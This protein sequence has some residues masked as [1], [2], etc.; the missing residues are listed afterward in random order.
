MDKNSRRSFL[1]GIWPARGMRRDWD[2]RARE[3]AQRYI[4]CGHAETD[5]KFW[6]SGRWDLEHLVLHDVELSP[7]AH[8]LEIGC[9][10]GRLLRPLSERIERVYGVDIS[11]EM[12]ARARQA[13]A[14]R[15]NVDVSSTDG[16]LHRIPEASLDFVFSFIV[17]QHVPA[18]RA[19][20]RYIR[21]S[22]R[23][24]RGGGVLRFQVDGRARPRDSGTDSWLGVWFEPGELQNQLS[25]AQFEVVNSWGEGTH[26]YWVTALRK[27]ERGRP[28]TVAV[29]CWKRAWNTDRL[30]SLLE[31]LGAGEESAR[32]VTSGD[33]TLRD[34]ATGFLSSQEAV[35]ASDFVRRA[36]EVFLGR[37]ADEGGLAFYSKEIESGIPRSNTVDCLLS[38]AEAEENLRTRLTEPAA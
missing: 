6:D 5:E 26:Y 34:L 10:L 31:R 25:A 29:R 8:A 28:D 13:L 33:R 22:A 32:A 20:V 37:P 12:V 21:E 4:A 11:A 15:G 35:S 1:D 27:R 9:G 3:D 16:R 18:K 17:F 23:V 38:S 36:Y 30:Q 2:E 24:L 14:S 19:V 7:R